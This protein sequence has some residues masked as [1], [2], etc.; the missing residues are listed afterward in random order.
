M[1]VIVA[2]G[3]S[4]T[5]FEAFKE[6][7]RESLYP[8]YGLREGFSI[9]IEGKNGGSYTQ[10]DPTFKLFKEY[11]EFGYKAYN[12]RCESK[13][14]EDYYGEDTDIVEFFPIRSPEPVAGPDTTWG[15]QY[16]SMLLSI[17]ARV[18]SIIESDLTADD[19]RPVLYDLAVKAAKEGSTA[20]IDMLVRLPTFSGKLGGWIFE[21]QPEELMQ[22]YLI[23]SRRWIFCCAH[24]VDKPISTEVKRYFL[25]LQVKP[26]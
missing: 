18:S 13:P 24:E 21:Y 8:K 15:M 23:E 14:V 26:L 4:A 20:A 5:L 16:V 19:F 11:V 12:F 10:Y 9:E 17:P 6:E 7:F 3:L 2:S 1:E 22:D 25:Q